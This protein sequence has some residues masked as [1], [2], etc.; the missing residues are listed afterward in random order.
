MR[1]QLLESLS[2]PYVVKNSD[3]DCQASSSPQWWSNLN[4]PSATYNISKLS[5]HKQNWTRVQF[6][7]VTLEFSRSI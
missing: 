3:K 7:S 1:I 5:T 6:Q 4:Y 2:N